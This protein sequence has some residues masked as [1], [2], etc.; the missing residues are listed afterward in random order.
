[1]KKYN[2]KYYLIN[3]VI[4][5][6]F[7]VFY[8]SCAT[9]GS[10]A[11]GVITLINNTGQTVYY[12]YGSSTASTSWGSDILDADEVLGSGH[13]FNMTLN[14]PISRVNKYDFL[15]IDSYGNRYTKFNVQVRNGGTIS[16]TSSDFTSGPSV[17]IINSTGKTIWYVHI[18]SIASDNWG[19]D[20]MGSDE[21]IRIGENKDIF[22][23][24]PI[25]QVNRYDIRIIASDNT[26]YIKNNVLVS[27]NLNIEFS[28]GDRRN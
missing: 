18:S 13:Q 6:F 12:V 7:A 24:L 20:L 19:P 26:E 14:E 11:G 27:R 28:A 3:G 9:T 17:K 2:L 16:F 25:N 23:P 8:L 1:M 4:I 5:S 22:L 15:L 10:G 21:I